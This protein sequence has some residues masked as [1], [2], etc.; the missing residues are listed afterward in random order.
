MAEDKRRHVGA[1][2]D[3]GTEAEHAEGYRSSLTL[4]LPARVEWTPEQQRKAQQII[5]DAALYTLQALEADWS[6]K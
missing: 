6:H 1:A 3:E 4:R 5:A 2:W